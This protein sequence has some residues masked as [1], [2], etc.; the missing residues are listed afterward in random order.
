MTAQ[1]LAPQRQ[2]RPRLVPDAPA[3]DVGFEAVYSEHFDR[4]RRF[5][6]GMTGQAS[7][8]EDIAQETLLRAYMRMETFDLDRPLWPWLKCV[9]VR[10]VVDHS[11]SQRRETLDPDPAEE[12]ASD[13]FD[14]TVER[15]LLADALQSLPVRQ[16]V[17]LGLRYLE[18]WKSAEVAAALGLS[19]VAVEQLLLRARRRLSAEYLA[20]GGEAGAGLRV[21][22]WPLLFVLSRLRERGAKLR[23]YLNGTA[24]TQLTMSVEGATQ[25]V[26]VVAMGSV[27]L[28]GGVAM[29]ATAPRVA[30]ARQA[31]VHASAFHAE[32]VRAPA[33]DVA[34]REASRTQAVAQPRRA[35]GSSA[36]ASAVSAETPAPAAPAAEVTR[37]E[38]GTPAPVGKAPAQ[39]MAHATKAKTDEEVAVT[40]GIGGR[41]D[42]TPAGG[43]SETLVNCSGGVVTEAACSAVDAV[44][45][46]TADAPAP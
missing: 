39:P 9:A 16:R 41:L 19:R 15:Q 18:N 14:V 20:I 12:T 21:A 32:Q 1:L 17:A 3:D 43:I 26:A 40:V 33:A 46:T 44:D 4:L 42:E 23:Q 31:V 25:V 6:L 34:A 5:V 30:P 45:T 11:R 22:L 8:A 24:T 28:A 7:L 36:G 2:D 27:L 35:V 10:L 13:T 29:A 37:I 38:V